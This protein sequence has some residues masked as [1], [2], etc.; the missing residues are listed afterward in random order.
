MR[1]LAIALF[2]A[3][4]VVTIFIG[5][6]LHSRLLGLLKAQQPSKWEQLGRPHLWRNSTISNS[7]AVVGF[8]WRHDARTVEIDRVCRSLRLVHMLHGFA[9]SSLVI[10]IFLI[11]PPRP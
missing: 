2:G 3:T 7:L 5:L 9:L 4:V 6:F 11:P 8:I 1:N 10:L